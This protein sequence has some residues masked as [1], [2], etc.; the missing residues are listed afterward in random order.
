MVVVMKKKKYKI[1]REKVWLYPGM[2]R[3]TSSGQAGAWHFVY[4]GKKQSEEI[5]KNQSK[6]KRR[7][8]GSVPVEVTLGKS[9]WK[10]S[11]FPERDG[12]YLMPLKADIRRK[13]GIADGDTI[14]YTIKLQS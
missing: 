6:K 12:P 13:E 7:G 8:F 11:I 9:K 10:T 14:T 5:Q 3:S 4:V 1:N 2:A